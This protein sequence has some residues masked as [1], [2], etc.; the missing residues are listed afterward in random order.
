[1]GGSVFGSAVG[2][3]NPHRHSCSPRD[4]HGFALCNWYNQRLD[5]KT[6]RYRLWDSLN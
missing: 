5:P 4:S 6:L 1:M 2:N 3:A